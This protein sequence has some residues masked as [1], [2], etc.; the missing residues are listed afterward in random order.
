MATLPALTGEFSEVIVSEL[1]AREH[2]PQERATASAAPPSQAAPTSQSRRSRRVREQTSPGASEPVLC[3]RP[4]RKASTE[5]FSDADE[6]YQSK[7]RR[8][9]SERKERAKVGPT[10]TSRHY[11]MIVQ[12]YGMILFCNY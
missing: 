7:R 5:V 9:A 3:S 11:N 1:D 12:P 2:C 6:T 8:R 10:A 4:Q